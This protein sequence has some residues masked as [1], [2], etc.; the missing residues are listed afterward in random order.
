MKMIAMQALDEL[1]QQAIASPR[2]RAHLNLHATLDDPVQRLA[3]AMEPDTWI[4]PHRHTHTWELLYPVR[5]RFVILYFDDAGVVTQRTVLG[6]DCA[7][8]EN[9]AGQW[10]SVLSLD[11]GAVIFEVKHGPYRPTEEVDFLPATPASDEVAIA[12]IRAWY[13]TAQVGERIPL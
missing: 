11:E 13:A 8:I 10:H 2:R 1:T 12:R 5:G 9:A 6:E 4:R 3:V 7:L